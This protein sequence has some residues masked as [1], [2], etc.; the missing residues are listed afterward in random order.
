MS[1]CVTIC[2]IGWVDPGILEHI[3]GSISIRCGLNCKI[4]RRMENPQYAYNTIRCQYNSKLILKYLLEHSLQDSFRVIGVTPVDLYVP[5][6][7]FVFGLAQIQ[8]KCSIISLHRLDP[9]FY[10]QPSN[11]NLLLARVEKTALHELGH[12]LGLTHCRDRR[13]VMYSSTRIEDTDVKPPDFCSTC[14]EL[15]QWYL[16]KSLQPPS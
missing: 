5:I 11:S 4:Y 14:F 6:L 10:D 15:F 1:G 7:K 16:K 3:A 2:P 13:C 12:T 9:Q 8:G